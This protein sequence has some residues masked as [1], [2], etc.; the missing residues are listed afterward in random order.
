MIMSQ[1]CIQTTLLLAFVTLI[2]APRAQG[3]VGNDPIIQPGDHVRITLLGDDKN[4]TGEFEVAPDSTLKHPIYNRLRVGGVPVSMLKEKI[5]AFV[6]QYQRE[7]QLEVEALLKVT[8]SGEI[9]TPNIYFLA[10]ETN[11]SDVISHAGGATDRAN[12]DHVV[13]TRAGR[14]LSVNVEEVNSSSPL[15]TIESGDQINVVPRKSALS[16]LSNLTPVLG[17]TASLLSI[18][19]IILS[20]R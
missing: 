7:P 20:R 6:R 3:A 12:L 5:V 13:L 15:P 8:V 9:R 4:F 2:V 17:V 11:V 19:Y 14:Q 10:P 16:G 18:T 1:K